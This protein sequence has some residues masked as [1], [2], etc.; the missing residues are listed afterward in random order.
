V[1]IEIV[2]LITNF[3]EIFSGVLLLTDIDMK[4]EIV[5]ARNVITIKLF[6]NE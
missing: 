4:T 6:K 5:M 3:F 2:R 1:G